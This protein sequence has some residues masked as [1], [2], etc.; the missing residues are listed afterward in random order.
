MG[1]FSNIATS[2]RNSFI[3]TTATG[4][5][6][7]NKRAYE[8][9]H[10]SRLSAGFFGSRNNYNWDIR[11]G[12][13]SI[14][15]KARE[16]AQNDPLIKKALRTFEK[17]IVGPEGFVL[18]NKAF[19]YVKDKDG[20]WGK[21]YDDLANKIIQDAYWLWTRKQYCTIRQDLTLRQLLKLIIRAKFIDGEVFLKKVYTS[22]NINPFGYALQPIDAT[23]LDET[24]NKKLPNGNIIC[25]GVEL[26][27]NQRKVAYWFTSYKI[28]DEMSPMPIRKEYQRISADQ[29]YH[30]FNREYIGQL[31]GVTQLVA[32]GNRLYNLKAYQDNALNNA[33]SAA[34]KVLMLQR[35]T[36][37]VT[38][39]IDPDIAGEE[40]IE[41]GEEVIYQNV[42]PG[43]TYIV[44]EGYEAV[45]YDP[46]YPQNEY[47]QYT[48]RV[49]KE[50]ASGMG[51]IDYPTLSSD[52]SDV[53]Y[54]SIRHGLLDSRL[55][56]SDQQTDLREDLLEPSFKDFLESAI[57]NGY[58]KNDSVALPIVKF[59]K[60]NAPVFYGHKGDWVDPLKD[61]SAWKLGISVGMDS[62]EEYLATKGVDLEEHLD[63][64]QKEKQMMDARGLAFG[65][66]VIPDAAF[67]DEQTNNKKGK[68]KQNA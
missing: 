13:A 3:K 34:C 39:T 48:A 32:I 27:A 51:D 28:E 18:R 55:G 14:R 41:A 23:L 40:G 21:E 30:L 6:K 64:L 4:I 5:K 16:L 15:A 65:D 37:T 17:N 50:I 25:M 67:A 52:L 38:E 66:V 1:L 61:K 8:M 46:A 56:Y 2:F 57:L 68:G 7:I 53:N 26:D 54:T 20:K 10:S 49:T 59:D 19:S 35:R 62:L 43:E 60:F 36:D 47:E 31:R 42:S 44:P 22:K 24:L 58:F 9:A 63:Q 12:L 29:I 11:M 33:K 45:P